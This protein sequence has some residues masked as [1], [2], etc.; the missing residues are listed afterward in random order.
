MVGATIRSRGNSVPRRATHRALSYSPKQICAAFLLS[1]LI[2]AGI[3]AF[4]SESAAENEPTPTF[5]VNRLGKTDRLR[6]EPSA[7]R[8]GSDSGLMPELQAPRQ[9]PDGCELAFSPIVDR[10]YA[11]ILRTCIT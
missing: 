7:Q 10:A 1:G 4:T 6:P 2:A 9:I 11:N 3:T 5:S 8:T